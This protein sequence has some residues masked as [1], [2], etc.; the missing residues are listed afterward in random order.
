[1]RRAAAIAAATVLTCAFASPPAPVAQ[2]APTSCNP[3]VVMSHR[4][5]QLGRGGFSWT[6]AEPPDGLWG[7]VGLDG[8]MQVRVSPTVPCG[9]MRDV[10]NH[11]WMHTRQ[12]AKYG[13][14]TIRAY[15][16]ELEPVADCGSQLLGSTY[17]PYL[18][19]RGYG[20]TAYELA[21]ARSLLRF[22]ATMSV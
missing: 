12:F 8:T 19:L 1:M 15:G 9:Y 14:R 21:S 10:V 5:D 11:E 2:P 4:L 3:S 17:T 20:C 18:K 6:I 7:V 22:S 16:D 13:V